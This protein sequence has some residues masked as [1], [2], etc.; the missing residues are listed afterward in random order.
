MSHK[1]KVKID[2]TV[3]IKK[4][5]ISSMMH[6][7]LTVTDIRKTHYITKRKRWSLFF[8][9]F[10]FSHPKGYV[11]TT[12]CILFFLENTSLDDSFLYPSVS[13]HWNS[14]T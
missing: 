12:D 10:E 13:L 7:E 1:H 4:M 11:Q 9:G 3:C 6:L 8:K 5:D 14:C 2:E